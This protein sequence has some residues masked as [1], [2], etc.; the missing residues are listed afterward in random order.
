MTGRQRGQPRAR[1]RG[2]G[3]RG[4][5]PETEGLA[6]VLLMVVLRVATYNPLSLASPGRMQDIGRELPV[7]VLGVAGTQ[8]RRQDSAYHSQRV[9]RYYWQHWGH[10]KARSSGKAAGVSLMVGRQMA[11]KH[12]VQVRSPAEWL[13]G[14]GGF[15]RFK[16]SWLDLSIF[17]LYFP[18]PLALGGK[19]L[20]DWVDSVMSGLPNRTGVVLLG[21]YN[22]GLGVGTDN[23]QVEA[24]YCHPDSVSRQN[25]IG[26]QLI[27]CCRRHGLVA[28]STFATRAPTYCSTMGGRSAIDHTL[29]CAPMQRCMLRGEVWRRAGR[30][31]QIIRDEMPRDRWFWSLTPPDGQVRRRGRGVRRLGRWTLFRSRCRRGAASTSCSSASRRA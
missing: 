18:P 13:S 10:T 4:R 20:F 8:I 9:G 22:S 29:T 26:D 28:T 3:V 6:T 30:R 27:E 16:A 23:E 31:L 19:G 21:D 14:R 11:S 25:Y 12:I 2:T 15:V 5:S 7:D 17:V 24:R 1:M